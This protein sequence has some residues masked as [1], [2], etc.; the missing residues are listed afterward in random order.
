M[1]ERKRSGDAHKQFHDAGEAMAR[2]RKLTVAGMVLIGRGLE[3][4]TALAWGYGQGKKPKTGGD[5]AYD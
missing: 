2:R 3:A 5:G 4:G 1:L